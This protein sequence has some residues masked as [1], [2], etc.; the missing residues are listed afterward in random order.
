MARDTWKAP[1]LQTF[2]RYVFAKK[3]FSCIP[4]SVY[5]RSS[6]GP[7]E[8]TGSGPVMAFKEF[9]NLRNDGPIPHIS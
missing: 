3:P 2:S 5:L 1:F 4:G 7:G 9:E 6:R 8:A